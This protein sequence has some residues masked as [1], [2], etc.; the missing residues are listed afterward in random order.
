M[1]IKLE[2]FKNRMVLTDDVGNTASVT[3]SKP[4]STERM[5]VGNFDAASECLKNG[6]EKINALGY[7]KRNPTWSIYPKELVSETISQVEDRI[8]RELTVSVG[9]KAVKGVFK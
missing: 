6:A 9:A 3:S 4:F 8:F 7:F 5:L 1:H 2:I